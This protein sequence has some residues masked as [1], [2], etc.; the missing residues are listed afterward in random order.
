MIYQVCQSLSLLLVL[1][2]TLDRVSN[3]PQEAVA[4]NSDQIVMSLLTTI[5]QN[6]RLMCLSCFVISLHPSSLT[7]QPAELFT[8]IF[9]LT[10]L[11]F[12]QPPLQMC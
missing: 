4:S 10:V 5:L 1:I 12:G 7:P 3:S 9:M 8:I 2:V 6:I 11:I